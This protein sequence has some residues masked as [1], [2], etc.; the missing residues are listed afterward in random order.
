M[1]ALLSLQPRL[2]NN[3][4]PLP[5]PMCSCPNTPALRTSPAGRGVFPCRRSHKETFRE[6]GAHNG[7]SVN[8]PQFPE[9]S[10][11]S[12]PESRPNM[13]SVAA[14][15]STNDPFEVS[16]D[17]TRRASSVNLLKTF[18]P[19]RTRNEGLGFSYTRDD[20]SCVVSTW[21]ASP[22]TQHDDLELHIHARCC[23]GWATSPRPNTTE[24]ALVS[25][26]LWTSYGSAPNVSTKP[27]TGPWCLGDNP[28]VTGVAGN[29]PGVCWFCTSWRGAP[30]VRVW[31]RGERLCAIQG[32]QRQKRLDSHSM[33]HELR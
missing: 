27:E 16:T 25:R 30:A 3:V 15:H 12:H 1:A 6:T 19:A 4:L 5:N 10:S 11:A 17:V 33:R 28:V 13:W 29:A 22:L 18:T 14:Y 21:F 32:P 26:T 23:W 9:V 7:F 8:R 2:R 31:N 20:A 24:S